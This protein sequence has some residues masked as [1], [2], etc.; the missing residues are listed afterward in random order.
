MNSG[1]F[2]PE[3]IKYF[4]SAIINAFTS[5]L[6]RYKRW[7]LGLLWEQVKRFRTKNFTSK[8][9]STTISSNKS[10]DLALKRQQSLSA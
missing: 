1:L 3:N 2:V 6:H 8:E 9:I 10:N 7:N 4:F 5:F